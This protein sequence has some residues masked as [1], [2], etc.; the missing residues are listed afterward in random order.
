MPHMDVAWWCMD[1]DHLGEN[2][3]NIGIV[4][5]NEKC[6]TVFSSEISVQL[7]SKLDEIVGIS[8][9]AFCYIPK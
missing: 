2:N 1:R 9:R 5:Q 7:A 8:K 6:H 3:M 4:G